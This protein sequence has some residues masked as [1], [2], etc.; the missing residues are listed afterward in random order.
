M[1]LY[2]FEVYNPGPDYFIDWCTNR[3]NS[4]AYGI[5]AFINF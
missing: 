2:N 3:S 1:S 5:P 4:D